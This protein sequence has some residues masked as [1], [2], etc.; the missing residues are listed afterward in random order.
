MD[1][2]TVDCETFSFWAACKVLPARHTSTKYSICKRVIPRASSL[3]VV[4]YS[5][6]IAENRYLRKR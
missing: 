4:W 1:A 3:W 5:F 6:I 2:D